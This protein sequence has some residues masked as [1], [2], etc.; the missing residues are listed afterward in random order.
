M[1]ASRKSIL[2]LLTFPLLIAQSTD[3]YT[4][5]VQQDTNFIDVGRIVGKINSERKIDTILLMNARNT[6]KCC[7]SDED[8]KIL[9]ANNTVKLLW[10]GSNCASST[11]RLNS[12]MLLIRCVPENFAAEHLDQMV[13]CLQNRRNVRML[14][15]WSSEYTKVSPQQ[16]VKLM[17]EQEQL[18]KY[19]AYRRLLNVI[20][21][22]RDYLSEGHY[23][24]YT[25]FPQ[26]QLQRKSLA[27]DCFPDRVKD[28]KG[29]AIRTVHDQLEPWSLVWYDRMGNVKITGFLTKI[30][31]EFAA[32]INGS[33]T[34]PVAVQPGS[35][36]GMGVSVALLQNNTI[37]IITGAT[38]NTTH[39]IGYSAVLLQLD[40]IFMLPVPPQIP[41]SELLLYLL[42]SVLGLFLLIFLFVFAFV[43]TWQNLHLRR[44]CSVRLS[45]H[46]FCWILINVVLRSVIGQPSCTRVRVSAKFL[47]RFLHIL[48]LF[49]GIFM[50]TLISASLQSCLTSPLRRPRINT[51]PDLIKSSISVKISPGGFSLLDGLISKRYVRD[52]KK[53]LI[54]NTSIDELQRQRTNMDPH[55][56]YTLFSNLWSVLARYQANLPQ[57]LFYVSDEIY[58]TKGMPMTIPMQKN[59]IY[60]NAL[61]LMI[62]QFH[63]VG[64]IELWHRQMYD[65]MV[66]ARKLNATYQGQQPRNG[67]FDLED[68]YW[69]WC[70]YGVGVTISILVFFAEIWHHR[71]AMKERDG[72]RRPGV[73]CLSIEK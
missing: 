9:S 73:A 39:D 4:W 16:Q 32:R 66:E 24:T 30:L 8:I 60:E 35:F 53:V 45:L 68:F 63:S 50:S 36:T 2:L 52:L 13:I 22:Y 3:S 42:N 12:E 61:S 17:Q 47:K 34:Y 31:N 19:C 67:I 37:D 72:A 7:L 1:L 54:V 49:S 40:W 15:I 51:F 27:D 5:N 70:V 28:I 10:S 6:S 21:I 65:D 71:R 62:N 57:P 38:S 69:L 43:L 64:L 14:F 33:I 18:F 46:F 41:D 48:L 58:V 23:Y 25:Y 29:L 55:Y 59:S 11:E 56:G 20:G 26:F 44:A